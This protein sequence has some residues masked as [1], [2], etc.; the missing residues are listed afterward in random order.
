M[1]APQP[2]LTPTL[3]LPPARSGFDTGL[4]FLCKGDT[5]NVIG[6]NGQEITATDTEYQ[7]GVV[8]LALYALYGFIE[9]VGF[10]NLLVY[11][12]P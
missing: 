7:H 10:N 6:A 11:R 5:F 8:R 1:T 4:H 9:K 3:T 2:I 12:S